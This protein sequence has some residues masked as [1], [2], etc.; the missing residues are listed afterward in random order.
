VVN[1]SIGLSNLPASNVVPLF[2]G[3]DGPGWQVAQPTLELKKLFAA[4]A[5]G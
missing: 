5:A 1:L 2:V 4:L 3:I